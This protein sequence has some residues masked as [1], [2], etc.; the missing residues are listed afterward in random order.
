MSRPRPTAMVLSLT[1]TLVLSAPLV[2]SAAP[3]PLTATRPLTGAVRTVSTC[4]AAGGAKIAEAV[5]PSAAVKVF[6]HGWGHGMG[7]SQYGAQ[8][9]AR[10]GCGYRTILGTYYRNTSVVSRALDAPVLLSLANMASTAKLDAEA[11]TVRWAGDSRSAL[12]P[13]GTTWSV[14]RLKL[15][16]Q[17][18]LAVLDANGDRQLFVADGV[19]LNARHAGTVVKV[20]PTGSTSGLRSRW[21]NTRFIGSSAG[22]RVAEVIGGGHG[23]TAVQK[24]LRGL[25]EVPVSWPV[26]ALKAQVVAARTYLSSKYSASDQA[27]VLRVTTADQVYRGYDQERA[28]TALGGRWHQA[29]AATPGKVIVDSTGRTIEAMYSSSMGG[30]TENRQYVYGRYGISYLKAVDDSRWDNASDN[31]YR[32]WSKGFSKANLAKRFGFDTVSSWAVAKRGSAARLTGIRIT[33]KKDGETITLSFTGTQARGKLGLRSPGFT[34]GAVPVI[35]RAPPVPPATPAPTP[36]PTPTSTPTASPTPSATPT[37]SASPT[38]SVSGLA[39]LRR[40]YSRVPR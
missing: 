40:P 27:Y 37:P 17:A 16:G 6:G 31:P 2:A 15:S 34:F 35:P 33:G 9:A 18:G 8:G 14:T 39:F 10:L 1:A 36:T 5:T 29:V 11:G 25:G 13:Q 22:I 38:G 32:R 20:R 19:V 24:Y 26:E 4:P 23:D 12:Q 30:H 21:G 28:D 7:M 3:G